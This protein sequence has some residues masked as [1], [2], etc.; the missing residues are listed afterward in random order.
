MVERVEV[1]FPQ[2]CESYIASCETTLDV[3][4]TSYVSPSS[5]DLDLR[6]LLRRRLKLLRHWVVGKITGSATAV[7]PRYH[8]MALGFG[9]E[10]QNLVQNLQHLHRTYRGVAVRLIRI[11]EISSG[12]I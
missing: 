5:R 9:N 3:V 7:Q 12:L 2:V 1:S 4:N 11:Q 10:V 6:T 8:V